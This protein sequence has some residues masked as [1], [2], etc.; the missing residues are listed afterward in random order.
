MVGIVL[1]AFL[2]IGVAGGVY[3]ISKRAKAQPT[4]YE[5]KD[6]ARSSVSGETLAVATT[7]IAP[8]GILR[9]ST[10][11]GTVQPYEE[12]DL[13]SKVS[14][15]LSR[16]HVDY[17]DRVKKNQLLAELD[18]PE[19][20][21]D[22]ERAVADL[23]QA[24]AAEHQ[25]EAALESAKADREAMSSAVEQAKAEVNRYASMRAYHEKKFARYNE[26]VQKQAVPQQIAD[27][28]EEGLD[29]AR[30]SEVASQ[31]AVLSAK[32]QLLAAGARVKKAEADILEAK[33]N[34]EVAAAKLER[35][36]VFVAY[37]KILA[38]YDGVI[39]KRNFFPGAFV[40]SA[41]EGGLIPLLT[42]ARTN[43]LRVVTQVPDR[44]VPFTNVGD[45]AEVVLDALP[46]KVFKAKVSRFAETEDPTSRTMHTEIDVENPDN[47]IRAGMYGI[48]KI[49]LD[50]PLKAST[51]PSTSLAGESKGGKAD[52][53]II[54]DGRAKKV[55]VEI[56][57]DDGIHVEIMS[58]LTEN[59][60]VILNPQSVTEGV[61]VREFH[62]DASAK[63]PQ[64]EEPA[65]GGD[66]HH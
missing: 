50:Q 28:E 10:Q 51:L 32:A 21:K 61:A 17:G 4:Q 64:P 9:A 25:S 56:G 7:H 41:S 62:E 66:G 52:V 42:V 26:L 27:E 58:G 13:Y 47:V 38:P 23:H 2:A 30:A 31:K 43:K 15:Y 36:N 24:Q 54:K 19:V 57:A 16:L 39:T 1:L 60:S 34:V 29:S 46:G 48:A 65:Q 3:Q 8:G 44:D 55:R 40:R 59:E 5:P 14:G 18:D 11:I 6:S 37:T 22:D 12:A 45:A 49:I 35:A 20:V 63:A 33:A 53:Y